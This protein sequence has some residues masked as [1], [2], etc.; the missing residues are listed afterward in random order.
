MKNTLL[1]GLILIRYIEH[2]S[3]NIIILT[4]LQIN[5]DRYMPYT[6]LSGL[7]TVLHFLFCNSLLSGSFIQFLVTSILICSVQNAKYYMS[8]IVILCIT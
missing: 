1:D 2:T 7:N 8:Y 3:C 5:I 6:F 4:S